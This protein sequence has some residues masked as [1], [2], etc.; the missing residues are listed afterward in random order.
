[1]DN[2]MC[3]IMDVLSSMQYDVL[4]RCTLYLHFERGIY[5]WRRGE[6]SW[7]SMPWEESKLFFWLHRIW[8]CYTVKIECSYHGLHLSDDDVVR[9]LLAMW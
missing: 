4:R 7:T 8:H 3:N 2:L 1:M 5:P 9:E 6:N